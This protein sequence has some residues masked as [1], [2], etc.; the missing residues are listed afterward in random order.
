MVNRL[1]VHGEGQEG[2]VARADDGEHEL[3]LV[4]RA[5]AGDAP[6]DDLAGSVT[7]YLS[8]CGSL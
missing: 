7:K 2:D 6:G 3:A 1:V 8:D 5:G 4:L